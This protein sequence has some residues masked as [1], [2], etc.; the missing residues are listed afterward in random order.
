MNMFDSCGK[1]NGL[2]INSMAE[3]GIEFEGKPSTLQKDF[4]NVLPEEH[5]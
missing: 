1:V 3:D 5:G 4:A 2:K